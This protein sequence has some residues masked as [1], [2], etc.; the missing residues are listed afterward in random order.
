MD[1][2]ACKLF[3]TEGS[4]MEDCRL[5][6]A[7]VD[8]VGSGLKAEKGVGSGGRLTGVPFGAC[9]RSLL[10]GLVSIDPC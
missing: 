10:A 2:E 1:G 8:A 9:L 7:A 4:L 5:R 6:L 3:G